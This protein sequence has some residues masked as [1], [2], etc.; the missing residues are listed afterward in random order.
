MSNY[1]TF[2]SGESFTLNGEDYVGPFHV[3]D[4]I[5]YSGP[6][7]SIDAAILTNKSNFLTKLYTTSTFQDTTF[8][9]I[10]ELLPS[11]IFTL[12]SLDKY[13]V[14]QLLQ[15]INSNNLICYNSLI[16]GCP[17]IYRYE[18][19]GGH[20]YG[21]SSIDEGNMVNIP[22][23]YEA[24]NIEPFSRY[25]NWSY[26]DN[27]TDSALIVD[28]Y[29]N[30]KY[31]CSDGA[32]TYV[33][34]G[35]FVNN[36][37]L[38]EITNIPNDPYYDKIYNIYN[39]IVNSK[40]LFVKNDY[41]E[42]YDSSNYSTC[43]NL[44]LIDR[45]PLI[46]TTTTEYI[47][48]TTNITWD[49]L[50]ATYNTKFSTVNSNNPE[51]IKFGNNVRTGVVGDTLNLINKYSNEIYNQIDL[52][53][54]DIGEIID[55]DVRNIDDNIIILNSNDGELYVLYIDVNDIEN[56][57]N[58]KLLSINLTANNHKIKFSEFDSNV[59]YFY[60]E[61]EYQSRFISSPTYP[62]GRLETCELNYFKDY[63]WNTT[64][65]LW[66]YIPIK[67]DSNGSKSNYYYNI[68]E[69]SYQNNNKM[70]SI[71]HNIGRIYAFNQPMEQRFFNAI[72]LNLE[73]NFN[74]ATCTET[75]FG[76][77]LNIT[78]SSILKDTLNI[79]NKADNS[80]SI[81]E[82][83]V[84]SKQIEDFVLKTENLYINGNETIN[85]TSFQ[86]IIQL[87]TDIQ[88]KILPVSIEK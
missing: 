51:F 10:D 85:I 9:N 35:N 25:D 70:Y 78:L 4:G 75:S 45:I 44:I 56:S 74:E 21:L 12:D 67:W 1:Y 28:T 86:R 54:F 84:I 24:V 55:L 30:F 14:D 80:F 83:T 22:A 47:W 43:N 31:I 81:E 64:D 87:I 65:E 41:I 19:N 59:F 18:E 17:T 42:I 3:I 11:Y 60:N 6:P 88:K 34:S 33:L 39:D 61:L 8:K 40:M 73:Q 79:L 27:I 20:F 2:T 38:S 5:A 63:I 53:Q 23:K 26:L 68:T 13:G 29:E 50:S 58:T 49:T 7:E 72:P 71:L 15:T 48:N 16:L 57:V 82:R 76:L 36:S 46:P 77:Y 52:S 69:A 37:P 62:S 66:N 32:S